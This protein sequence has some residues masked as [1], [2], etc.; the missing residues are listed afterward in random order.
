MIRLT[1]NGEEQEFPDPTP[2]TEYVSSLGVNVKMIAIAYNGEV[3][4]RDE[5]AEITLSDGDA[6]EVVRAVGGG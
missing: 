3:L 6:L 4:R 1:I 2:L 5:W